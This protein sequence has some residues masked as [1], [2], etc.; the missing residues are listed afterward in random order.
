MCTQTFDWKTSSPPEILPCAGGGSIGT[1]REKCGGDNLSLEVGHGNRV[2]PCSSNDF[3]ARAACATLGLPNIQTFLWQLD[4]S[5]H[6]G[7]VDAKN[8]QHQGMGGK[9]M[10]HSLRVLLNGIWDYAGL[11]PPASLPWENAW[12]Q[13]QQHREGPENWMVGRFV[14]VATQLAD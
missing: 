8:I 4:R 9:V 12:P 13:F 11:F 14:C 1:P 3:H 2:E 10:F 6:L 5:Q 7:E